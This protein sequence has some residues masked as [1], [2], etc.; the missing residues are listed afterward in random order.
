M[1]LVIDS[2]HSSPIR[3]SSHFSERAHSEGSLGTRKVTRS[4]G[5]FSRMISFISEIVRRAFLFAFGNLFCKSQPKENPSRDLSEINAVD[6]TYSP[7]RKSRQLG[8]VEPPASASPPAVETIPFDL[9]IPVLRRERAVTNQFW[10]EV[11]DRSK[12]SRTRPSLEDKALFDD[13]EKGFKFVDKSDLFREDSTPAPSPKALRD[14]ISQFETIK[15]KIGSK[16]LKVGLRGAPSNLRV[17]IHNRYSSGTLNTDIRNMKLLQRKLAAEKIQ[18][19]YIKHKKPKNVR[20]EL[21][22]NVGFRAVNFIES[23]EFNRKFILDGANPKD[24]SYRHPTSNETALF[25]YPASDHNKAFNVNDHL[26]YRL[27][28]LSKHY[29]VKLRYVSSTKEMERLIKAE[30]KRKIKHLCLGGHGTAESIKFGSDWARNSR[31]STNNAAPLSCLRLLATDASIF[32]DACSSG[33]AIK[34]KENM[35]QMVARYAPGR[36][37]FSSKINLSKRM[38]VLHSVKPYRITLQNSDDYT[39]ASIQYRHMGFWRCPSNFNWKD[40]IL[41]VNNPTLVVVR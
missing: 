20:E 35:T 21:L 14:L 22:R 25:I 12:E 27:L 26:K 29:N 18:S 24:L 28:A 1:T 16:G 6:L 9:S 4:P 7:I 40:I 3:D 37:V 41:P 19:A 17:K 38:I 34:G 32:L 39:G 10:Q 31:L 33:K 2:S 15:Q 36:K 30:G 5:R 23:D 13:L 11:S 8:V